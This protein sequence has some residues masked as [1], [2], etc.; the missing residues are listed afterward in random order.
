MPE[1]TPY[2][3]DDI[4]NPETSHETSDVNVRALIWFMV[5]FVVF[6]SRSPCM[7]M[8][9]CVGGGRARVLVGTRA[10]SS[11]AFAVAT[12]ALAVVPRR[13]LR[14]WSSWRWG[15]MGLGLLR[16]LDDLLLHRDVQGATPCGSN[17]L[18][19]PVSV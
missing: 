5:I 6:A 10:A 3:G 8:M 15:S 18:R 7:M 4:V 11:V 16:L 1:Q 2:R 12:L 19:R 14:R 17:G 9:M 13:S